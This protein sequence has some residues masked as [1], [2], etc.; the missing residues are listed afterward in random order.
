MSAD[1][2]Q[3]VASAVARSKRYTVV[4]PDT[5][6]RLARK[7]LVSSQ[8]NVPDAVK[9]TKRGLHEIYGAYLPGSAPNY[10]SML[11]RLRPAAESG[12]AEQMEAALDSAMRVHA[13]TRERLD[14]LSLFYREVFRRVPQPTVIADLACGL[15]PLSIPWMGLDSSVTYLASDID[16]EQARFLGEAL[17]LLGVEHRSEVLDLV[18]EPELAP[19]DLTLLLKTVPCLERQRTG[20]G[21]EL[22]ERV[23]SRWLVVTFPTKSLGQRSKGMFQ[24]HSS[25]FD[26]YAAQRSWRVEQFELSNEL[27]YVV[28]KDPDGEPAGS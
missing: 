24:T 10:R 19:A 27:V 23:P 4:A 3:A 13:S 11:R 16:T 25:A 20:V 28:D 21:W 17:T 15:N 9:R 2:V 7:A 6:R 26:A 18:L 8:G 5:V 22:L 12:D 14:E 1:D